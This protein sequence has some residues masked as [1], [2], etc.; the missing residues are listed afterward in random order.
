VKREVTLPDDVIPD[1][2]AAEVEEE[3]YGPRSDDD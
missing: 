3:L 2:I 1:L